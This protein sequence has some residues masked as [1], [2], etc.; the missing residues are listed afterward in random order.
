MKEIFG[1]ATL[2]CP[3][4]WLAEAYSAKGTLKGYKYQYS[5]PL[6]LHTTDV[7]AYFGPPTVNQGP[8]FVKAFQSKSST[9][10]QMDTFHEN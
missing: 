7:A 1:D 3:S 5:V 4:Y 6:A 8:D 9:F 10:V 2:I